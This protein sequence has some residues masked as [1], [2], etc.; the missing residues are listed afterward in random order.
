[1]RRILK[2]KRDGTTEPYRPKETAKIMR[3]LGERI[4]L[5]ATFTL[6][7]CQQGGIPVGHAHGSD[8]RAYGFSPRPAPA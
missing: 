6:D 7:A 5:P 2:S 8:C 1:L 3:Q 4:A